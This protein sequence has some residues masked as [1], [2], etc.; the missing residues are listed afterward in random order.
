MRRIVGEQSQ[1]HSHRCRY[2][3]GTGT[4]C[5]V[6]GLWAPVG[7]TGPGLQVLEGSIMP[8]HRN[9]A[10]VWHLVHGLTPR[11]LRS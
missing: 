9:T 11:D 1:G 6:S 4:H 7:E 8:T 2:V 5:P 10:I 3:A